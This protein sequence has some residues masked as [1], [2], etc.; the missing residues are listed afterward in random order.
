MPFLLQVGAESEK[1]AKE[2]AIADEEGRKVAVINDE[3]SAKQAACEND[4]KRA[5]PS[6]AAA[7]AALNILDKVQLAPSLLKRHTVL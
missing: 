2:K 7:E 4:L 3:V 5:E 6:L 1:V